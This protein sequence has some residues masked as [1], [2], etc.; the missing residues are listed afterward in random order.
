METVLLNLRSTPPSLNAAGRANPQ[1]Q[2]RIKGELQEELEGYLMASALPRGCS[3]VEASATLFFPTK[4]R[5][6]EGNFRW[7][8][9]KAL[10]D[11]LTNGRWLPDDTPEHFRFRTLDFEQTAG[12]RHTI[13]ALE[14]QR[15]PERPRLG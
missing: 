13:I 3:R 12:V 5:R 6:D 4:R 11:A 15:D 1:K 8:L 14:Y 2:G 9:E 7:L 10:G